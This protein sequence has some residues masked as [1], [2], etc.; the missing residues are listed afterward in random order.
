MS[1]NRSECRGLLLSLFVGLFL[2]GGC[3]SSEQQQA[4]EVANSFWQAVLDK[5]M[6]TAKGLVT[7]DSVEYLKFLSNDKLAAQNFETGELQITDGVAEIATVLNSGSTAE[8]QIPVR[9]ILVRHEDGWLVDVQKTLGSMVSGAMGSI[10]DQL[11]SFM[12]D[13]LKGLDESLSDSI[14]QLGKTLENGLQDLQKELLKPP[15]APHK[16]DEQAI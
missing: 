3:M 1:A 14:D 15:V 10:V 16:N 9:T 7:W 6:E 5:D 4:R 12:Q 13:G 8:M 2:L 11:N